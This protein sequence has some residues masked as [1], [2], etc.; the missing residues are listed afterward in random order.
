MNICFSEFDLSLLGENEIVILCRD[1]ERYGD[2]VVELERRGVDIQMLP[3]NGYRF[4]HKEIGE[5]TAVFVR[6]NMKAVC[7]S[8]GHFEGMFD[9]RYHTAVFMEYDGCCAEPVRVEDLL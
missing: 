8:M 4:S 2:L 5:H 6:T 1:I 3:P 9:K 7:S